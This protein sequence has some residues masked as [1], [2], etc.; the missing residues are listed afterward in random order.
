MVAE[1]RGAEVVT[2]AIVRITNMVTASDQAL[3]SAE[4]I[5]GGT[6]SL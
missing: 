2:F 4:T 1:V 5:I 3:V 6:D